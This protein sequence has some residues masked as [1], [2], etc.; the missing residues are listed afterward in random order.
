MGEPTPLQDLLVNDRYWLGR[1]R[2]M[3]DQSIRGRDEA[4]ARLSSGVGWLWTVYTGAALVGVA[5]ADRPLPGW[6]VGMLVAPALL[7]VAAYGL[8][9]WAALPVEVAFDPRVVQEI[10]RVHV[11]ATQV[12]QRRLRLAGVAA[13]LGALA[14]V[15]A[16]VVT[17]TVRGS[18]PGPWLSAVVDR[19]P[20]D[21]R[22]VLVEGRMLPGTPVTVTVTA[23]EQGRRGPV[24]RLVVADTVGEVHATIPVSSAGGWRVQAAWSDREERWTLTIPAADPA[25]SRR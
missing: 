25:A 11:R 4:A 12:K 8:A 21:Q 22:V 6:V 18:P 24:A 2:G 5:L 16:V 20:G 10:R 13:G 17:A 1:A 15:A 23:D 14:V 9:T 19:Q 7:L 3:L